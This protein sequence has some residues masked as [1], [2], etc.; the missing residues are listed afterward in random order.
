MVK[1]TKLKWYTNKEHIQIIIIETDER[2]MG[3]FR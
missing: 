1:K 2:Q 3:T